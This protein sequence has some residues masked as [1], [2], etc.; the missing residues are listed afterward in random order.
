MAGLERTALERGSTPHWGCADAADWLALRE[1]WRARSEQILA[2]LEGLA[3]ADLERPPL[4]EILPDFKDTL[5]DRR[6]FWSGHVFHMAYH[7]GQLGSLRAE[8]ELGWWTP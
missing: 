5:T 1:E 2:A 6:R 8:L 4:V 7:L 3:P